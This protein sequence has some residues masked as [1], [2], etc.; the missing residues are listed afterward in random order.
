MVELSVIVPT[1]NRASL[2]RRCLE[3]LGR[4]HFDAA[5]FEVIAVDNGSSDDTREVVA[6]AE[7]AS[8]F[9]LRYVMEPRPGLHHSRHAGMN[10][11]RAELLA[12]LDDDAVPAPSWVGAVHDA[13]AT[14]AALIGGKCLPAW[15]VP[16]PRWL[17]EMWEGTRKI[18]TL[19]II[20]LGDQVTPIAPTLVWGCN[21]SV[22]KS[23]LLDAGGFHP[24]AVPEGMLAYRGDGESH[25]SR[26]VEARGEVALYHPDATVH[27]A[28][29]AERMT[30]EYFQKRAY[31]QGVSESFTAIRS[32]GRAQE[33]SLLDHVK[34]AAAR[35]LRRPT[36]DGAIRRALPVGRYLHVSTGAAHRL[37]FEWHRSLFMS[38]DTIREWV[39]KPDYRGE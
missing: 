31:A 26:C 39:L 20:D 17:A 18:G 2:L 38:D 11:A 8:T 36:V 33:R 21:F 29:P 35:V 32:D 12:Y 7:A 34:T 27:H 1:R 6:A 25:I 22:R 9:D 15:E 24:D 4:Q 16:P 14:G 13:F 3:G 19:S 5:R 37:G 10:A 23:V 30:F 28:V